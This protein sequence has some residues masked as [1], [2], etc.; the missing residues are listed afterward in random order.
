MHLASSSAVLPNAESR[1]LLVRAV[2]RSRRTK[3]V[4]L[5]IGF[6]RSESQAPP[7]LARMLRGGRGGEVRLKIYLSVTL[8][9]TKSPH[10]I[11]QPIPARAWAEMLALPDPETAGARRVADALAWLNKE[12]FI[13]LQRTSGRPPTITLRSP[14]ADDKGYKRPSGRWV[15][16]P[17]TLWSN[18]WITHL[19]GSGLALLLVLLELQGGLKSSTDAPSA[20]GP[21]RDRYGLSDDTW[22]RAA[23]ELKGLGILTVHRVPQGKD[24]DWQRLRNTYWVDLARLDSPPSAAPVDD[25]AEPEERD[26]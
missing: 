21:R 23:K 12:K 22:T 8:L 16:V 13:K 14:L 20:S 11:R 17:L 5:P 25:L 10:D 3:A 15:S 26:A 9:A 1:R 4:Q 7:P 18:E 2:E 24:F 19:S 6:V